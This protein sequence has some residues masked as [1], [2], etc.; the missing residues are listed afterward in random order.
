M[1]QPETPRVEPPLPP[2]GAPTVPPPMAAFGPKQAF[3]VIG[4]HFGAQMGVGFVV[5]L[6]GVFALTLRSAMGGHL[7]NPSRLPA[8]LLMVAFVVS[9]AIGGGG[10]IAMSLIWR[11]GR[12][13]SGEPTGF[14]LVRPA[15]HTIFAGVAAAIIL[16]LAFRFVAPRLVPFDSGTKLGPVTSAA[17][18]SPA[19]RALWIALALL[20]APP[21]E[22]YL[23]R[24]V[25]LAGM[26]A[27]FSTL[28]SA[29][30]VTAIFVVGHAT[31]AIA[32]W[33][34]FLAIAGLGALTAGLRIWS[35]SILPGLA[36][37][38]AYNLVVVAAAVGF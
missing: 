12:L 14:G 29:A 34:A 13:H 9:F 33:P 28:A 18:V 25:L 24:G 30:T 2:A 1:D 22:E 6:V 36:A 23:F 37:H 32:Y 26:R 20:I 27:R 35:G 15:A 38:V 7:I 31:E 4:V 16:A 10:A 17:L 11:R 19:A 3:A 8:G 5:A 21:L